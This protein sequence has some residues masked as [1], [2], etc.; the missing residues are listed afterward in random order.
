MLEHEYYK[1]SDNIELAYFPFLSIQKPVCS[2]I[3]IHGGG[4]HSGAG[5]QHL[6][7]N[8]QINYNI[9]VFLL[10]LRGHGKSDGDRGDCSSAQR[11]LEDIKL[12]VDYIKEKYPEIPITLGGHSSGGGLVLNY[13]SWKNK[14]PVDSNIFVSPKLGYRSKPDDIQHLKTLLQK[15]ELLFY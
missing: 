9:N 7:N 1:S 10:D 4:A 15:P 5:Y 11:I 14:S 2:L 13:S 12:F 3:F 8:L 6:A